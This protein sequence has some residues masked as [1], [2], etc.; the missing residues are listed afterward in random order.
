MTS[1]QH[2]AHGGQGHPA[3]CGATRAGEFPCVRVAG[4]DGWHVELL[5]HGMTR[6]WQ[7]TCLRHQ[8]LSDTTLAAVLDQWTSEQS[9]DQ[10]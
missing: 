10:A 4:H 1:Q 7:V 2:A 8:D 9:G 3:A 6:A 5:D